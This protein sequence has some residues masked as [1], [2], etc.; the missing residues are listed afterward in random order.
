MKQETPMTPT[1]DIDVSETILD[2]AQRFDEEGSKSTDSTIDYT[3]SDSY[4]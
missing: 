2:K 4:I 1:P 3:P